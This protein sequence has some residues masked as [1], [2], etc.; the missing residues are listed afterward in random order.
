MCDLPYIQTKDD[1]ISRLEE[2]MVYY[3]EQE[4]LINQRKDQGYV[5]Y[6]V[7]KETRNNPPPEK[8]VQPVSQEVS[9]D[10]LPSKKIE[11]QS[12]PYR[13]GWR[14]AHK[15]LDIPARRLNEYK[16]KMLNIAPF[17]EVKEEKKAPKITY[18]KPPKI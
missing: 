6:Q 5:R 14:T 2:I 15:E 16:R 18:P 12:L 3:K 7:T 17:I 11:K 10:D 13:R 4:K 9:T 1:Q 8:Q